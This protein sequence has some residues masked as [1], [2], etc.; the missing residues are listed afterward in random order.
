M[1]SQLPLATNQRPNVNQPDQFDSKPLWSHVKILVKPKQGGNRKWSCNYC[2]KIVTGSYTKVKGHLLKLPNHNVEKCLAISNEVLTELLQEHNLAESRKNRENEEAKKRQAYVTLPS[3]SDLVQP[4]KRKGTVTE[5]FNMAERDDADKECARMIY[6]CSLPFSLVVNPHFK[7]LRTTLLAQEKA[8]IDGLL[9]PFR[10]SWKK[11]GLSLCS[12]GWTDRQHHPLINM[13]AA[14]GGGAMFLKAYDTSGKTK[15]ADYVSSLFLETIEKVGANNVVQII[16]DNAANFKAAAMLIEGKYPHIFWTPCVVHSL[17]LALRSIC[18]PTENS[19][20]YDQCKWIPTMTA[21]CQSIRQF[22]MQHSKALNIFN[23]YSK[24]T[25]LTIAETRFA[26][27]IIMCE[28]LLEVKDALVRMILDDEWKMF[29]KTIYEKKADFVKECVL[30][31][32]WWDKVEYFLEFDPSNKFLRFTDTDTPCLHMVYDMWDSMIEDVRS[33]I[34]KHEE[35]DLISGKSAFFDA[36]QIVFETRW[37]K[38]NTPLLCLAHSLV[39][40]YYCQNWLDGG[41]SLTPRV[42]PN[43]DQEWMRGQA[44]SP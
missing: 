40:K 15:G 24:L 34:L 27:H 19:S 31:D 26:S 12:D 3:G 22:V 21:A 25:L 8:H 1:A 29:R 39:P 38:S 23:K 6:A 32:T 4:K 14:S 36:I 17:N 11:K 41:N 9:Q 30:F 18:D 33:I 2:K 16:T 5:C 44:R 7:R 10:D 28:R 13:M 35:K 43:E 37:N 42:A 20:N